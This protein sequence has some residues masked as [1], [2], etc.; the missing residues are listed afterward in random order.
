MV[1]RRDELQHRNQSQVAD[2]DSRSMLS[3]SAHEEA[4]QQFRFCTMDKFVDMMCSDA[5]F[6]DDDDNLTYKSFDTFSP[7]QDADNTRV[8][9][10]LHGKLMKAKSIDAFP[11]AQ[12][13]DSTSEVRS[14]HSKL[15]ELKE[16]EVSKGESKDVIITYFHQTDADTDPETEEDAEKQ[17]E[18]VAVDETQAELQDEMMS[19]GSQQPEVEVRSRGKKSRL[20]RLSRMFN[21]SRG[22][23]KPRK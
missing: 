16:T 17:H 1:N 14:L 12:D 13:A 23:S 10:S 9:M 8:I 11:A 18:A 4:M 2:S 21:Q 7:A 20:L 5:D 3:A 6:V 22:K 15:M 19:Q